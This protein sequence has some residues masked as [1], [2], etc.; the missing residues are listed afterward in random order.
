MPWEFFEREAS[1][2]EAWYRTSRGRRVDQAEREL[3]TWLLGCFPNA[4]SVLEIGSGTG[5]FVGWL[6]EWGIRVAGLD[7]S[8]AMLREMRRNCPEVPAV[9]GDANHLPFR[10]GAVDLALFVTTLEFLDDPPK[11]LAEA[12]RVVRQGIV[13]VVLNR[14]SVGGLSRRWGTQASQPLLGRARDYSAWTLRAAVEKAAGVRLE[15]I[16]W[17]STLF[18]ASLWRFHGSVPFGDVIG[19]AVVLHVQ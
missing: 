4:R 16:R 17:A 14:W 3:L 13:L 18:P 8:T 12:I 7:R 1:R 19:M 5:H 11:A 2:Y 15:L 9:L 6:V 10:D